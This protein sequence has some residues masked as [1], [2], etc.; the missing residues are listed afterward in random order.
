[1]DSVTSIR[2][3]TGWFNDKFVRTTYEHRHYEKGNS[4]TRVVHHIIARVYNKRGKL[5]VEPNQG[6]NIDREI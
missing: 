6:S 2:H 4:V 1:M 5:E 3:V